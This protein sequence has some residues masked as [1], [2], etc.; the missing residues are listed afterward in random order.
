MGSK[1]TCRTCGTERDYS[2]MYC[3]KCGLNAAGVSREDAAVEQ[4][5]ERARQASK[6][7]ALASARRR[8]PCRKCGAEWNTKFDACPRCG[9]HTYPPNPDQ[10]GA[11]HAPASFCHACGAQQVSGAR[12]CSRCGAAVVD[13]VSPSSQSQFLGHGQTAP[14]RSNAWPEESNPRP[15]V[16]PAAP[17]VFAASK[18]LVKAAVGLVAGFILIFMAFQI[19]SGPSGPWDDYSSSVKYRIDSMAEVGD[20]DGL[21]EEFDTADLNNDATLARTGHN[22]AELM[23]YIDDK[24]RDAGCYG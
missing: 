23:G 24:M 19:F 3:P 1:V 21:Q 8:Y 17:S 10:A 16:A 22:N 15:I 14:P 5:A 4:V 20:C 9:F 18:D 11:D 2:Y 12:F 7:A 6:E 13:A